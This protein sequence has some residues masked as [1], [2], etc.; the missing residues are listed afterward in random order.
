MP[1]GGNCKHQG[2]QHPAIER[3]Y[4]CGL[5]IDAKHRCR[6]YADEEDSRPQCRRPAL[7]GSIWCRTHGGKAGL[8]VSNR[9]KT[10]TR[11]QRFAA[12]Y[13]GHLD[14]MSAFETEFRR[15]LGRIA[16]YDDQLA[17]LKKPK[18]VIWGKTKHEV[19]TGG[20]DAGTTVTHEARVNGFL[21]LQNWERKHLLEMSKV[22]I[23]AGLEQRKL[24]LMRDYVDTAYKAVLKALD[25][26]GL[27][28]GAPEVQEALQTALMGDYSV[29]ALEVGNDE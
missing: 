12:P 2:C 5:H 4:F 8:D 29:P 1:T 26:L 9:S 11:M 3:A 16:W 17:R 28:P 22:W 14:P 19:K 21:E 10:L 20:E 15:T 13:E 7:P 24:D 23:S 18:D 27:D 6:R 25:L